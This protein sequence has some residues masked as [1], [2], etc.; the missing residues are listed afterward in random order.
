MLRSTANIAAVSKSVCLVAV[1]AGRVAILRDMR[2]HT[3]RGTQEPEFKGQLMPVGP[4][5]NVE[6]V[7]YGV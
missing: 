4:V 6:G 1:L 7:V 3:V 5:F 2:R